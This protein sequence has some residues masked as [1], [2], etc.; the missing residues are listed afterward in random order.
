MLLRLV[1]C[2]QAAHLQHDDGRL[3]GRMLLGDQQQRPRDALLDV[4][5]IGGKLR[6]GHAAGKRALVLLLLLLPCRGAANHDDGVGCRRAAEGA[7]A[8][9]AHASGNSNDQL[10]ACTRRMSSVS[11]PTAAASPPTHTRLGP[12]WA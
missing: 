1:T 7:A 6:A 11:D 12:D 4:I 9:C 8:S 5:S 10:Q 2:V 3:D